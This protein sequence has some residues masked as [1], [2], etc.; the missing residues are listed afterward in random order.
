ME[1]IL[2]FFFQER[3]VRH[4]GVLLRHQSVWKKGTSPR[5]GGPLA[6]RIQP[7]KAPF[8]RADLINFCALINNNNGF[9]GRARAN[10]GRATSSVLR[11]A[12]NR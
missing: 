7:P 11:R 6:G 12:L 10:D 1:K 3:H 4:Y 2:F 5:G 8:S 9:E